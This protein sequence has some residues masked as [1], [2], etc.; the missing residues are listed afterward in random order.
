MRWPL[1]LALT[2]FACG[3][4]ALQAQAA[5]P[6]H[7]R[8][9]TITGGALLALV[10]CLHLHA[11]ASARAPRRAAIEPIDAVLAS[12][13][14]RI[15]LALVA[16]MLLGFGYA[17]WRAEAR[18]ADALDPALEG[19]D[20]EVTGVVD[21]LPQPSPGGVRFVL[22]VERA[23]IGVPEHLSL[24]WYAPRPA[25]FVRSESDSTPL[26]PAPEV[27]AGERWRLTVRL[28]RPHGNVNPAGF[29]LEAW[30][31]QQN[32]RATGYVR[33]EAPATR[34]D[35]FVGR[36][37]DYVQRAR[38][39]IRARINAAL[40][41]AP[42]AG[43]LV[44]L[45]IGDQRAIPETQ[46]LVF[47]R[48]GIAHLV[49][50]S[51]LHVTVFATLAGAVAG[52]LARRSARLTTRV[53]ARKI[54]AAVG[55]LFAF[56]YVLL[57]GAEIPAV[58]TLLMLWVAALGLWMGRP[59]TALLVWLWALTAVL[60]FDPWAG[61][62][63][64]LWLSFGAVGLLLYAGAGRL[65]EAPATTWHARARSAL[66]EG[67][68]TQWVVTLG[69]VPGTLAL[70]G[71]VSLVSA[72]ANAIAIPA[73]TLGVVPLALL[74]IVVPVDLLWIVAHMMLAWLMHF[75]E[76]LAALHAATWSS[77]APLPWTVAVA[78]V[79]IF[80]TLAPR[81][82]PGRALG[83]IALLP[84][85]MIAPPHVPQGAARMTV[86][87]V[88][89]GLALVV[90]TATHALVYDTGPRFNET[91]DA[92]GRIVAPFLRG[93]GIRKLDALVVSHQDLDHSG[94]AMSLLQ[95]VP[96]RSFLSSIPTDHPIVARAATTAPVTRCVAGQSWTWDGVRFDVLQPPPERYAM[97][98][99]KT[100]DLSCVL[101]I[102]TSRGAILLTGDMEA[103]SEA[104]LIAKDATSLRADI[105]VVPHHG[106]RT[107]STPAF[108]AAV[109][110]TIAI[111]TPGYRNRFG[112]PRPEVVA[113]YA[114]IDAL[115][116]RTDLD[117]AVALTLGGPLP[118][119]PQ[120]ERARRP[121]YW[122]DPPRLDAKPVD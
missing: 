48:T 1:A 79:G 109:A 37:G 38:E 72:F 34:V 51:G 58:R 42:Y 54:A 71:Q 102:V 69:L 107:S 44:A 11:V 70:F 91:T 108:V 104:A 113:R 100:N 53:P 27:H 78:M 57:A 49:S 68:R 98:G 25:A 77:H 26:P 32:L 30:L 93:A 118:P 18:L 40:P 96:V 35:A 3:V 67:T 13:A 28:K 76:W 24:G 95:T 106:S 16:T 111:F 31:L 5:L 47:N 61:L 116:L 19:V 87:D 66:C 50:I 12:C 83:A 14:I 62:T 10:G 80:W 59:G 7:P 97:A 43:V 9:W 52:F 45:T 36:F 103:L 39:T 85:A 89:Q 20:L 115:R 41:G 2:A 8:A 29:D 86:L 56:C 23:A 101:R 114:R 105:L 110:P 122:Y 90:E 117:G 99:V 119:V 21:D 17:G 55:A 82:V 46:W 33:T 15:A 73:V 22:A 84:L 92:G 65:A 94:G 74:G 63:P 120:S 64:G 60:V 81:A 112:H 6:A 121:R 88:G 75:L 4:L